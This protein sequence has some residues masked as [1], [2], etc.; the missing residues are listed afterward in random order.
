MCC[1]FAYYSRIIEDIESVADWIEPGVK[2]FCAGDIHPSEP[3]VVIKADPEKQQI[4]AGVMPWGFLSY[5]KKLL[6]N[7]RAE[8]VQE[9][10]T[11]ADSMA[12]RRCV[13]PAGHFYEWDRNKIRNTFFLPGY[14]TFYMA[15]LYN[16]FD[17]TD[18]FTVL[19][20]GANESMSPV[21]DR[22][23]LIIPEERIRDW[24]LEYASAQ[25][26]LAEIPPA[27][28]REAEYEQLSL[29]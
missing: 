13:I 12:Y 7:A 3:A 28:L 9:K 6:I 24:I 19:T 15:G 10:K 20:T 29:F 26:I 18:R 25:E 1:R 8:S 17:Q 2:T 22:M 11:F 5:D 4:R 21:H 27:F 14:R 16:I 23:P